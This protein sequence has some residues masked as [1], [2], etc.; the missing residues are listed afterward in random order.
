MLRN[1]LQDFYF[2]FHT[3]QHYFLCHDILEDAWKAN[4]H[5]SKE[6]AIVSLILTATGCYHYRRQNFVGAVKSFKKALSV[7][8]K[9]DSALNI[10]LDIQAYQQQIQTLINTVNRERTFTPIQL[11]ITNEMEEDILKRYPNYI[12]TF[13]KIEDSYIIDHHLKR[14]RTEVEAARQRALQARHNA[15]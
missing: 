11:P 12:V 15:Q 2:Q 6:D 7:I 5:F 4:P 13:Y 10:G 1:A 8:R 14:D 9:F 3:Q